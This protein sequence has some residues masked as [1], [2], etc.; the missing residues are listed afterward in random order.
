M[1]PDAP[2]YDLER[3][4]NVI[5]AELGSEY[6]SDPYLQWFIENKKKTV[7]EVLKPKSLDKTQLHSF[8][9]DRNRLAG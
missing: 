6:N 7:S 2:W 8:G 4:Q 5:R 9:A 1:F 3:V